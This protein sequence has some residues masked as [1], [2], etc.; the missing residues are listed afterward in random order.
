MILLVSSRKHINCTV[1]V[2]TGKRVLHTMCRR[3]LHHYTDAVRA[4]QWLHV[5]ECKCRSSVYRRCAR[6]RPYRGADPREHQDYSRS[7]GWMSP[8]SIFVVVVRSCGMSYR[9]QRSRAGT[10]DRRISQSG[11]F[12]GTG[13]GY[14]RCICG[15]S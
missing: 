8:T 3:S 2:R 7:S 11:R 6:Y 1:T 12:R 10:R 14:G 13:S 4:I 15:D 9:K 5:V